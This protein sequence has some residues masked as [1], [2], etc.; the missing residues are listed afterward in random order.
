MAETTYDSPYADDYSI[1]AADRVY[2]CVYP[3]YIDWTGE[4]AGGPAISKQVF[5]DYTESMARDQGYPSP[6]LSVAVAKVLDESG[7]P[8]TRL[9]DRFTEAYGIV[10]LS[11]AEVRRIEP[12]IGIVMA[13]TA[14]EPWHAMLFSM[15]QP[16]LNKRQ[17]DLLRRAVTRWCHV[18]RR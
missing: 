8:V 16:R 3:A 12:R 6:G 15:I 14:D 10:E 5:Q 7:Q 9:L 17:Q 13:P 1:G 4:L 2:R 18:P 11:V